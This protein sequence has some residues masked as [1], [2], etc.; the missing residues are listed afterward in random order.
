MNFN[1][2][3]SFFSHFYTAIDFSIKKWRPKNGDP[4]MATKK[5][6]ATSCKFFKWLWNGNLDANPFWQFLEEL[7]SKFSWKTE[8][9]IVVCSDIS[10]H[11]IV[12]HFLGTFWG[13]SAQYTKNNIY[14]LKRTKKHRYFVLKHLEGSTTFIERVQNNFV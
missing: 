2:V 14:T 3:F 6:M 4:K 12:M 10:M 8:L 13:L 5:R 11:L 1:K 9:G 7:Q